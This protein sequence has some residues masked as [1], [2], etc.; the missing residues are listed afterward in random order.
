M[1]ECEA[2]LSIN[3]LPT[4]TTF[5]V[6]LQALLVTE[7]RIVARL[8]IC[9]QA[10]RYVRTFSEAVV[11]TETS[12]LEIGMATSAL[13]FRSPLTNV[14]KDTV[15]IHELNQLHRWRAHR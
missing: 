5:V 6:R 11:V 15:D 12:L 14:V 3:V 10:V 7:T 8:E 4:Q 9:Y 13:Q 2:E 1:K